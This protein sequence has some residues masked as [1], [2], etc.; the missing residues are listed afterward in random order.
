MIVMNLVFTPLFMQTDIETVAAMLIPA[1]IPFNLIKAGVN[2][3]ITFIVYKL[4]SR[5]VSALFD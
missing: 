1:I 3:I 5:T 4:V 2:A